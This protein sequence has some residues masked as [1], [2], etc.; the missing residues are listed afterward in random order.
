[1][2]KRIIIRPPKFLIILSM[3]AFLLGCMDITQRLFENHEYVENVSS[4]LISQD[5]K[6]L[7]FIGKDY[8]Y[9]F[10]ASDIIVKTFE[11]EFHKSVE[12]KIEGIY[13]D[14]SGK[15]TGTIDLFVSQLKPESDR[16]S[17]IGAGYIKH[18]I[19][20]SDKFYSDF[21]VKLEGQR[22][23]ADKKTALP[24]QSLNKTYKIH[25]TAEQSAGEKAIKSL[26]TPITVTAEGVFVIGAAPFVVT[27]IVVLVTLCSI[28]ESGCK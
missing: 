11:S 22:F 16:L 8:H 20:N 4:V 9:I 21:S 18:S 7:V 6:T 2:N 15:T 5:K 13:V 12:A 14:S 19:S 1:M 25:V 10:P 23:S 28:D 24:N 26:L 17:S 27:G 3:V